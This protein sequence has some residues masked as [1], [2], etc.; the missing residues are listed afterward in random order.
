[1]KKMLFVLVFVLLAA[2]LAAIPALADPPAASGPNVVRFEDTFAVFYPDVRNGLSVTIG[3]DVVEDCN[4]NF[5]PEVVSIQDIHVPEDANRIIEIIHGDELITEVW[6]FTDFDCEL[7]TTVDPVGA[8]TSDL[9]STDNDLVVFLTEDNVNWNAFGF[10]AHG[11]LTAQD[12]SEVRFNGVSRCLWDG[13]DGD[14]FRCVDRI[15]L[16]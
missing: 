8:G 9:V 16:H 5:D 2:L 4:G 13:N 11:W 12:G 7:F 15:G 10:T 3:A 6:P 14:T 1:M